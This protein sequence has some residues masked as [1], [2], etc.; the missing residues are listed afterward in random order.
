MFKTLPVLVPTTTGSSKETAEAHGLTVEKG[1][2]YGWH[3]TTL[4][5]Q[6]EAFVKSP[7]QIRVLS[8]SAPYQSAEG[9]PE[10]RGDQ[11]PANMFALV[12]EPSS[13]PPRK[14]M[15]SV[16]ECEVAFEEQE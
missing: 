6:A 12:A 5:P 7:W 10:G 2:K 11:V 14:F 15:F 13:G 9:F 4:N 1:E 3:K 8:G 16:G